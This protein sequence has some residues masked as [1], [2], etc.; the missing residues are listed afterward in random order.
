MSFR[1]FL[2]VLSAL[3]LLLWL[4]ACSTQPLLMTATPAVALSTQTLPLAPTLLPS[5]SPAATPPTQP[6]PAA[7]PMPAPTLTPSPR[8]TVGR[9]NSEE[10]GVFHAPSGEA[11]QQVLKPATRAISQGDEMWTD[12]QGRALLTF[13]DLMVRIYRDSRLQTLD[14][15]PA[16]LKLALGQGAVLVGQAPQ[17]RAQVVLFGDPPRA[18]IIV[19]GTLPASSGGPKSKPQSTVTALPHPQASMATTSTLAPWP[20]TTGTGQQ[21][22]A[23]YIAA[24]ESS[25][26]N[27][28]WAAVR[29]VLGA[30]ELS[31]VSGTSTVSQSISVQSPMWAF[32]PSVG[33]SGSAPPPRAVT[34]AELKNLVRDESYWSLIRDIELDAA[35]LSE[36]RLPLASEQ[37]QGVACPLP[38]LT[39]AS[40]PVYRC[41][42]PIFRVT[43]SGQAAP[44]CPE[45]QLSCLAWEWGDGTFDAQEFPA[46]HDFASAGTYM[47]T[48][49][50]Y[51]SLGQT[52]STQVR[53]TVACPTPR[54]PTPRPAPTRPPVPR[55]PETSP[56]EPRQPM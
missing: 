21:V 46:V 29:P 32:I 25:A 48:V 43:L 28:G 27:V 11:T 16:G 53:L 17:A 44:G 23:A 1:H 4:C 6:P 2:A 49:K 40:P 3:F 13:A 54:P 30:I 20:P 26:G 35:C 38:R 8:P 14:V 39:V 33:V 15:T 41:I 18:R 31:A 52:S 19:T 45:A 36:G 51:D 37:G 47:V 5:V 56:P 42:N 50:A 10:N 7:T 24:S 22:N 9:L 34:F 55:P 12:R